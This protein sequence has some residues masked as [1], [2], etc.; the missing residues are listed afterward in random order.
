M[1]YQNN[2]NMKKAIIFYAID[3]FNKEYKFVVVCAENDVDETIKH[4]QKYYTE[5]YDYEI[6]DVSEK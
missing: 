4:N 6:C 3:N 5:I 2:K 1:H